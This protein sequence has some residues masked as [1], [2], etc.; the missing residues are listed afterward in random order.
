MASVSS[1]SGDQI[2]LNIMPM[3][4]IFSILILFLLMNFSTDPMTHDLNEGV[5]LPESITLDSLDEIPLIVIS[6]TDIW[7]NEKK[8]TSIENGDVI[9]KDKY[10]GGIY[11]LFEDLKSYYAGSKKISEEKGIPF[12][13]G[14]L[15]LEIDKSHTFKLIK[16]VLLSSEQANFVKFKLMVSKEIN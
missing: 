5:E 10:Q 14:T 13:E 3:L 2:S 15:T 7:I 16:R 4:D 9:K 6:K 11:P 8:I 1:E 12:E